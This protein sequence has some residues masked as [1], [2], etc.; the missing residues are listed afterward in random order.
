MEV[1]AWARLTGLDSIAVSTPLPAQ[2]LSPTLPPAA[3]CC[4]HPHSHHCC[5]HHS[6]INIG[7]GPHCPYPHPYPPV[8]ILP[9]SSS[10]HTVPSFASS[11][12]KRYTGVLL[13]GRL[14]HREA[15]GRGWWW[16]TW[17]PGIQPT[18]TTI[19]LLLSPNTTWS[20]SVSL[21]PIPV[22]LGLRRLQ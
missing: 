12:S 21:L 4:C 17:P 14:R 9:N 20:Q 19:P 7:L 13:V 2:T 15:K 10:F 6:S 16:G 18:L 22:R 5:H 11:Q 3:Q 8:L 1:R